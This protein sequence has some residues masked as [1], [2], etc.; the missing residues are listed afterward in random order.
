LSKEAK[1]VFVDFYNQ[2]G[3]AALEAG[4][5]EEA[6]WGKL[7]GYGA[8]FALIGQLIHEPSAEDV[9][10]AVMQAACELAVSRYIRGGLAACCS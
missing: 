10:A 1:P 3:E 6:A 8:R 7:S 4:E 5:H 9:S 2:C